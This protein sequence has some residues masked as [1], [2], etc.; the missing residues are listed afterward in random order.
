MV[1]FNLK[2]RTLKNNANEKYKMKYI[3]EIDNTK[4]FNKITINKGLE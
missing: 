2:I 3:N 1:F 4:K